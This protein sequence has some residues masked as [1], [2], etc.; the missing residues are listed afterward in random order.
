[1]LRHLS[2]Y[3]VPGSA[4]GEALRY[5]R[6]R[7]NMELCG[8]FPDCLKYAA[9]LYALKELLCLAAPEAPL[10]AL[11]PERKEPQRLLRFRHG[12]ISVFACNEIPE[13]CVYQLACELLPFD[14][15]VINRELLAVRKLFLV[16]VENDAVLLVEKLHRLPHEAEEVSDIHVNNLCAPVLLC[17]RQVGLRG[18]RGAPLAPVGA[19]NAAAALSE[20]FL[21]VGEPRLNDGKLITDVCHILPDSLHHIGN[22]SVPCHEEISVRTC[23]ALGAFRDFPGIFPD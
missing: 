6:G 3:P 21:L 18:G 8:F 20:V 1:M 13:P 12:G 4:I 17:L 2:G 5:G 11:P 16:D 7:Y 9:L 23:A 14:V 10:G 19:D 15:V 22:A